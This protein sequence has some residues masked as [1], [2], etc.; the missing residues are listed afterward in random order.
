VRDDVRTRGG[1]A[2]SL[3]QFGAVLDRVKD[4]PSPGGDGATRAAPARILDSVSARRRKGGA[5]ARGARGKG[6]TDMLRI[7]ETMIEALKGLR[8][9]VTQIEGHDRDLARQ[10]RRAASSVALNISE[11][12]GCSGGTRRERYRNALGSARETGAC[13][14]V[15]MACGYV[16]EIDAALL[17]QLDRVRAV[18]VK[19]VV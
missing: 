9:V 1:F 16:A 19:N 3:F 5:F 17:D 15:A 4:E 18:L 6:E 10:L 12:S 11:G 7:Y 2:R 8:A 14:D 13:L